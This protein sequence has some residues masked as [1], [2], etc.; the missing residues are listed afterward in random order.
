MT[1]TLALRLLAALVLGVAAAVATLV[2]L[3]SLAPATRRAARWIIPVAGLGPAVGVAIAAEP[4]VALVL[5]G[6]VLVLIASFVYGLSRPVPTG[7][8]GLVATLARRQSF[9]VVAPPAVAVVLAAMLV[10]LATRPALADPQHA[11]LTKTTTAHFT[12]AGATLTAVTATGDQLQLAASGTAAGS[13]SAHAAIPT[14]AANGGAHT[15]QGPN[16]VYLLIRGG[17]STATAY[18]DSAAGAFS[19]TAG[20]TLPTAVGAG[21]L[22]LPR[23]DGSF[24]LVPGGGSTSLVIVSPNGGAVGSW[25]ATAAAFSLVGATGAGAGAHA[26]KRSDGRFVIVHAAGGAAGAKTSLTTVYTPPSVGTEA[27]AA[28]PATTATVGDGALSIPLNGANAGKFL[29]FLGGATATANVYDGTSF[30]AAGVTQAPSAIGAGA[31]AFQYGDGTLGGATRWL[32]VQAGGTKNAFKV[33]PAGALSQAYTTL[34]T[35]TGGAT[36]T[37]GAGSHA[38]LRGDGAYVVVSGGSTSTR[39]FTPSTASFAGGPSL[40]LA[41]GVGAHTFQRTDGQMVV[42]RGG[43][44]TTTNLY[45][46]GWAIQGTYTSEG[47]NQSYVDR[48]D[49]VSW[50]TTS[51]PAGTAVTIATRTATSSAALAAATYAS[52]DAT[53]TGSAAITSTSGSA[54]AQAQITLRRPVPDSPDAEAKVWLGSDSLAYARTVGA[55]PVLGDYSLRFVKAAFVVTPDGSQTA[56]TS[57]TATITLKYSTGS[58]VTGYG[59]LHTLVFSGANPAPD[60]TAPTAVNFFI[61]TQPFGGNTTVFFSSGAAN[62]TV[63]LYK[64]ETANVAVTETLTPATTAFFVCDGDVACAAN[65]PV[66][67]IT[68]DPATIAV[69][70]TAVNAAKSTV[71]ASPVNVVVGSSSTI[72]VTVLDNFKNPIPGATVSLTS[73]RGASDT[74]TQP[75]PTNASGVAVG[76]VTSSALGTATIT[77]R[78][79][80]VTDLTPVTVNFVAAPGTAANVLLVKDTQTFLSAGATTVNTF[81]G[82]S[83]VQLV[84]TTTP[85]ASF[86]TSPTPAISGDNFGAGA[87][88]LQGI[89]GEYLVIRGKFNADSP[90]TTANVYDGAGSFVAVK[91]L[92]AGG[93]PVVVGAGGHSLLVPGGPH[94]NQFLL[95]A[96]NG[97][98]TT[99]F[100]NPSGADIVARWALA[101]GPSLSAAAGAGAHAVA[102]ADGR[103]LIVHGGGASTTSIYNPASDGIAIGPTLTGNAGAGAHTL[104]RSDGSFLV[105]HGNATTGTSILGATGASA[106]AG[107]ALPAA[108]GAGGHAIE[109][110]DAGSVTR[111]LIVRGNGTTGTTIFDGSTSG[112]PFTAGPALTAAANGGAHSLQRANGSYLVIHGGTSASVFTPTPSPAMAAGPA[113]TT[114][115][116]DGSHA[117]QQTDGRYL[118]VPG[119][120]TG[121]TFYDAGWVGQGTYASE[122]LNPGD[123]DRWTKVGWAISGNGGVTIQPQVKAPADGT[124]VTVTTIDA[125]T[126]ANPFSF[127]APLAKHQGR[128]FVTLTRPVLATTGAQAKVW[129]GSSSLVRRRTQ[130]PG[131]T[132]SSLS[133]GYLTGLI[134]V[135]APSPQTAGS[136]FLATITLKDGVNATITDYAG[137]HSLVFDGANNA[138]TGQIPTANGIAFGSATTVDFG[139]APSGQATVTL[140]LY[141]AET[142]SPGAQETVAAGNLATYRISATY[143]IGT[144][145]AII[146]VAAAAYNAAQST[147]TAS[148]TQIPNDDTTTSTL[149]L[150][151]RDQ[152]GNPSPGNPP[153]GSPAWSV[154]LASDRADTIVPTSGTVSSSGTFVATFQCN[155]QGIATITATVSG[156]ATSITKTT[157]VECIPPAGTQNVVLTLFAVD[158]AGATIAGPTVTAGQTFGIRIEARNE[159]TG[160]LDTNFCPSAHPCTLAFTVNAGASPDGTATTGPGTIPGAVF[161]GGIY[162]TSF[163]AFRLVC[164]GSG[165]VVCHTETSLPTPVPNVR[166]NL[167]TDTGATLSAQTARINVNTG[168]TNGAKSFVL[169]S[170]AAAGLVDSGGLPKTQFV[171]TAVKVWA[172]ITDGFGNAGNLRAVTFSAAPDTESTATS[173]LS[174]T[175]ATTDANGYAGPVTLTA[176]SS[177]K[178]KVSADVASST[179]PN[180][181]RATVLFFDRPAALPSP[182]LLRVNNGTYFGLVEAGTTTKFPLAVLPTDANNKPTTVVV[183][184]QLSSPDVCWT[185]TF[186]NGAG[187]ILDATGVTPPSGCTGTATRSGATTAAAFKAADRAN[188][189]SSSGVVTAFLAN[190]AGSVTLQ[191]TVGATVIATYQFRNASYFDLL[192]TAT[193]SGRQ[194][195]SRLD[196]DGTTVR[197]LSWEPGP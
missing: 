194:V 110:L 119:G 87:H 49:Q 71:V 28:G 70:P 145:R 102:L 19:A 72:T 25:T 17:G 41:A 156:S 75:G 66:Q 6:P 167:T 27:T 89:G 16:S 85:A 179:S 151:V 29:T 168:A 169:A 23:G 149:T 10:A 62:D 128:A 153:T 93:S 34:V 106:S 97:T 116:A 47:L 15:L 176:T 90:G 55:S 67:L 95:I 42:V 189:V 131:P 50:A 82:A 91:A 11:T 157:T 37:Q 36:P 117:L 126:A 130:D 160:N 43:G 195:R 133:L 35:G 78:V 105:V 188:A 196:W 73:S 74:I 54:W 76:S 114:A 125:T 64:A 101:P 24:L 103:F 22:S 162:N 14:S 158:N 96:G 52:V 56:G 99:A 63:T 191:A 137:S 166:L 144:T 129:L 172:R 150:T 92:N 8:R 115:A 113:L 4:R 81:V 170:P 147:F 182:P 88:A 121:T 44:N 185:A 139:V 142:A 86:V 60:G 33:D 122:Y 165:G 100:V 38:F 155:S 123:V 59:G 184:T 98:G 140:V 1:D 79:N 181:N 161:S 107:P 111:F 20:P 135:T 132:V 175:A 146:T 148:P 178:V 51:A 26:F 30:T 65:A 171:E 94:V 46:A 120:A 84:T 118:V 197:V 190:A 5:Y 77:A 58:T 31:H 183:G 45:D 32:V 193:P 136:G 13:M 174:A 134:V 61:F 7:A 180:D 143:T 2:Y 9:W 53:T 159:N 12:A 3:A 104:P 173:A 152:F 68:S 141:R 154:T 112:T 21:G 83:G 163:S 48:Y 192:S 80:G 39:L 127:D 57:F 40:T 138:L 108:V 124:P 177:G 187:G 164:A 69:A 186:S 109:Y 18:Y